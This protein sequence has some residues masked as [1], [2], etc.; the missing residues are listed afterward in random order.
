MQAN[1]NMKKAIRRYIYKSILPMRKH[2]LLNFTNISIS[3]DNPSQGC[4]L[5]FLQLCYG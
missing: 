3:A 4:F 2:V 5:D 1:T